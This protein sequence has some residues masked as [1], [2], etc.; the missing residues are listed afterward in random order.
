METLIFNSPHGS[1]LIEEYREQ[2]LLN[3]TNR[4]RVV[5]LVVSHLKC[6]KDKVQ[7]SLHSWEKEECA[8]AI[9]ELFPSCRNDKGV[10]GYVSIN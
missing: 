5:S 9:V 1:D 7:R 4:K 3:D 8:K 6:H 2:G 10:L